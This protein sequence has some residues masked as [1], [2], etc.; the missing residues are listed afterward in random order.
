MTDRKS[1]SETMENKFN[2][3]M[4]IF[5]KTYS[6]GDFHPEISYGQQPKTKIFIKQGNINCFKT[7]QPFHYSTDQIIWKSW[8]D[9]KIPFFFDKENTQIF[10][11]IDNQWIINFDLI[12]SSFYLLSGWQEYFSKNRDEYGRFRFEESCQKT[13]GLTHIPVVNYYFDILKT[14][15][16]KAYQVKI[17]TPKWDQKDFAV[18]LTHDIDT[19]QS[20]WLEGSFSAIKKKNFLTPVRLI[21]KKIIN[22]D[23][24]FNFSE[25]ID[26]EK[27]FHA[28]STFF[29]IPNHQKKLGIKNADYHISDPKIKSVFNLLLDQG[30]EIGLHGSTGTH[31]NE[32][33]FLQDIRALKIPIRGNR[34]HFLL[35]DSTSTPSIL[36]NSGLLYDSSLGFAEQYGFR[37]SFCFPFKPYDIT[38]DRPFAFFEVPLVIMDGTLQKYLNL[39]PVNCVEVVNKIIKEV[40]KFGGC[41]TVLWHNTHFSEYKYPGWKKGYIGILEHCTRENGLLNKIDY[42]LNLYINDKYHLSKTTK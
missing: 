42:I 12:A 41:F 15:I 17:N 22:K 24:W 21:T 26:I 14:V 3:I 29:F 31:L 11:K 28:N 35:Y 10:Q 19:C 34:F 27:Q 36:D 16:E 18:C 32:R 25:I 9:T 38:H 4:D 23:A 6:L 33:S 20:A 5:R 39:S 40:K 30:Y 13:L 8:N 37:N 7:F 1:I 2:Y